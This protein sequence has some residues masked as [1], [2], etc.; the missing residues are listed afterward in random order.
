MLQMESA[1]RPATS[2]ALERI[3]WAAT[4]LAIELPSWGFVNTGTRFRV[5]PQAGVPRNAFEKIDDAATV[6]RYTGIAGTVALHIPW[7]KVDD[8]AGLAAY[9][10][11]RGLRIGGINSN[12]FQD[13]DYRLGS[14]CH[15]SAAVRAKAVRAIIECCEIA[16]LTG[17]K[18]VKV[19]LGDGTNYPGQDDLRW[20]RHRLVEGLQEIYPHLPADVRMLLEYKLYE[21]ALYSTDVQDWGQ[22]LSV[23]RIVGERATVCVDTGHHAM[24]VNIEQIVAILLAEGRLGGFDLNDKKYGDDDLIVGSIDP[25]QLFRIMHELVSA[26]RDEEDA[27][28]RACA[29]QV[30]YMLDQ[31]HNIEPKIPAMI[32]SV[33]NLQET[34]ARALLVDRDALRAAQAAGD[35]LE[36]NRLL[37]DAYQTDVRPMLAELRVG[38]GLPADPF[39]AYLDSGEAEA[40]VAARVGGSAAGWG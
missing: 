35:I 11:E 31:C 21:P 29:N 16:A 14:L 28:A 20:R 5:F 8:Y 32:R 6:G 19:W 13:E 1:A 36:A 12:T 37:Q 3:A 26:M 7:D 38:R 25:Y 24:G 33:M 15:P 34:F 18:T 10:A 17:S 39:R 27:T 23:C 2:P 22:A 9:A 40:R 30:V 4:D